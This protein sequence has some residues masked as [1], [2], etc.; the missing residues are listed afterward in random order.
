MLTALVQR[1]QP[2]KGLV[3]RAR[4]QKKVASSP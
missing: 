2:V 1:V 3:T 4:E